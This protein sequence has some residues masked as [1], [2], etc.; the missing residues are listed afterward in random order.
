[1]SRSKKPSKPRTSGYKP[2][3]QHWGAQPRDLPLFH[4]FYHVPVMMLE[5]TVRLGLAM[6]A[7]PLCQV[8]FAYKEGEDWKPGIESADQ[9]VAAF[10]ERN[11]KRIWGNY[12]G[13]MLDA[14]KWGWAAAEVVLKQ[15]SGGHVEV[16]ELLHRNAND[17]RPITQNGK[18][19][20]VRFFRIEGA[21]HNRVDLP[22]PYCLWHPFRPEAGQYFGT[23]ICKGAFSPFWD[24]WMDGGALDVRRLFMHKDAYGGVDVSYPEGFTEIPVA[25]GSLEVRSVPNRDIAREMAEQVKAGGVTSRPNSYNAQG[26][27]EWTITRA[28]VP[29]NPAHILTYPKDLD[30]EI[31][32]GMEIPDDVLE[33]TDG[34]GGAWAGKTVPQGAFYTGLELWLRGLIN[35]I[36]LQVMDPLVRMNFGRDVWYEITTKP[37]A[38]QATESQGKDK[39]PTAPAPQA[40]PF[41]MSLEAIGRGLPAEPFVR[42]AKRARRV[43][44]D[45]SPKGDSGAK[46]ITIGGKSKSGGG[47]HHGGFPVQIDADGN[48]LKG[49]PKALRGKHVSEVGKHF[50]EERAAREASGE[51]K[52]ADVAGFFDTIKS[53]RKAADAER[54]KS[55]PG[56]TRSLK[57]IVAYQ[58]EKWGMD[59]DTY[60]QFMDEAMSE[61]S[62][63]LREREHVKKRARESLGVDAGTLKRIQERGGKAGKGGDYT[64]VKGIDSVAQEL[65]SLYPHLFASGDDESDL[66]DLVIEGKQDPP[67]QT[68]REFHDWV[69]DRLESLMATAGNDY[70]PDDTDYGEFDRMSLRYR[71]SK[72][73]RGHEHKGKGE[74]G[75]QFTSGS[76]G[77]SFQLTGKPKQQGGFQVDKAKAKQRD[78]FAGRGDAKGQTSFFDDI[79]PA[80]KN[81]KDQGDSATK[82]EPP[83]KE[84][85]PE[86]H[87]A[88]RLE[89]AKGIMAKI[90]AVSVKGL[91]VQMKGEIDEETAEQLLR[92]IKVEQYV[93]KMR[94][95]NK[96]AMDRDRD[97][98]VANLPLDKRGGG[99]L[100]AQ[101]DRHKRETA[102][103]D[104]QKQ[105]ADRAA[106][107]GLHPLAV[108]AGV[109]S[110]KDAQKKGLTGIIANVEPTRAAMMTALHD[111]RTRMHIAPEHILDRVI[112]DAIRQTHVNGNAAKGLK[113]SLDLLENQSQAPNGD[114]LDLNVREQF[115]MMAKE[116]RKHQDKIL[117]AMRGSNA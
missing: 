10:V 21:E 99:S 60:A 101:I 107:D 44:M 5:P 102:K 17:V 9:M 73:A 104:K 52:F 32:R 66:W 100:N 6:R 33:S 27:E 22:F 110:A 78:L 109:K 96:A 91:V 2:I 48:I 58:A 4:A 113:Q 86:E 39:T 20:G 14:Q 49:G 34:A 117:A 84:P 1:M 103:A 7:G 56:N 61:E 24:K 71:M 67:S 36:K 111:V 30:T 45:A 95:I 87:H 85:T 70:T 90:P 74:G 57:K 28:S 89:K 79:D 94:P 54:E 105:T 3:V 41:R 97:T 81:V 31:Y 35:D 59:E 65:K 46:W 13:G 26:K 77:D 25:P 80:A 47:D 63:R 40:D 112:K 38:L 23:S 76:G 98:A 88:E 114:P 53:D 92:E 43:R 8:E 50:K 93:T 42:G 106:K 11:M 16:A 108:A 62:D 29:A 55:A 37:L 12:I 115:A 64:S 19:S 72:D 116:M 51:D 15:T 82:D 83:A 18:V 69:D 75:G 68:S